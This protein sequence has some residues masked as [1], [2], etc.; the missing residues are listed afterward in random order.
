[1]D[2]EPTIP[3]T[4]LISTATA[5]LLLTA[6]MSTLPPMQQP[7]SASST[8]TTATVLPIPKLMISTCPVLGATPPAGT[9]LQFEPQLPSKSTMLLNYV[10]FRTTD[11]PHSIM[12][13]TMHYP[14]QIDHIVESFSLH[15]LQEMVLI[16]FFGCIGVRITMVLHIR[17]TNASLTLYQYFC[18]HF[19]TNYH[20]P[21]PPVSPDVPP[22]PAMGHHHLGRGTQRCRRR[23][24]P[25]FCAVFVQS[26]WFRQS[27]MPHPSLQYHHRPYRLLDGLSAVFTIF[28][29]TPDCQHPLHIFA[30]SQG[31]RLPSCPLVPA[32]LL[33]LV[34]P[35][36]AATSAAC[37]ITL[38][39]TVLGTATPTAARCKPAITTYPHHLAAG[40][41]LTIT[42]TP[43]VNRD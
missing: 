10:H 40:A 22:H 26:T 11:L 36:A 29:A 34:E 33:G 31:D 28:A 4:A 13:V 43:L 35:P 20:K 39:R 17:A 7:K 12:L 1:M 19:C 15:T 38:Q 18:T 16:N 3:T 27:I 6:S 32:Q 9:A 30:I 42:A 24:N 2:V 23:S 25:P 41:T 5:S 37:R 8:T 21:H 14:P